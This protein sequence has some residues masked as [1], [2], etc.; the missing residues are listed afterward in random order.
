MERKRAELLRRTHLAR[1]LLQ[2][3]EEAEVVSQPDVAEL[4]RAALEQLEHRATIWQST[5]KIGRRAAMYLL[6]ALISASARAWVATHI[7]VAIVEAATKNEATGK[8]DNGDLKSG[9]LFG[10]QRGRLKV[11]MDAP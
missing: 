6:K 9:R 4:V 2:A 3:I 7:I 10:G 11:C 5:N 1:L 8:R